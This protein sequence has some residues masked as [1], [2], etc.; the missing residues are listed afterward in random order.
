LNDTAW[1]T[2]TSIYEAAYQNIDEAV[3]RIEKVAEMAERQAERQARAISEMNQL[4]QLLPQGGGRQ[5]DA[6]LPCHNLPVAENSQFFGRRDIIKKLDHQLWPA[7]T[8]NRLSSIALYGLGGI[9]KTQIALAYAYSKLGEVDA[10]LWIAAQ[11]QLSIRQ[12]FSRVAVDALQLPNAHP[13][14]HQENMLLVLLWLQKTCKTP[15][16]PEVYKPFKT[17]RAKLPS[18]Y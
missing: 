13:Q 17:N 9:G 1:S 7:D 2:L 11:D 4:Q 14:S 18:G 15:R 6:T 10:L 3:K 5:E 16:P 12:S 8:G